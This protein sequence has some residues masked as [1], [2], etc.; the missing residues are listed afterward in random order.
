ML[1]GDSM[2]RNQFESILCLLWQGL[3]NTKRMYET[4][5]YKITK[6]R[7]YYVFKFEVCVYG[8]KYLSCNFR[9]KQKRT[10]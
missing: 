6:G 4:H 5:G 9:S 2:N 10:L 3:P 8:R 1:V 7:G